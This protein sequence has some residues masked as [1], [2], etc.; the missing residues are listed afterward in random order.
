MSRIQ[1][2]L[3][4]A[5]ISAISLSTLTPT[6]TFAAGSGT[7]VPGEYVAPLRAALDD[8]ELADR[9]VPVPGVRR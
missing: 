4:A 3:L 7:T 9:V 8:P 2:V 5:S 1:R 6:P